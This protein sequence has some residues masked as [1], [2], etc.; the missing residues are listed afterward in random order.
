M[1]V[2]IGTKIGMT[3]IIGE[4]GIVT[5]VTI[6]QAGPATVTQI[7]TVES[8]GYNAVQLGYG[9]GKNLS[10]SVSGHVKKAGENLS[11]KVLKEFRTEGEPEVKIGDI[12]TVESFNLGDKVTVIGTSKG[13]GYAGTVKRWN[14][15][16][17]RNTHGFKGNIRRVGSI[18]SMYPQKVFKGKKMPG[19]MGHDQVTVKNLE[20]AYIDKENNLIGLKGAVPG[21]KKGIVTVEGKE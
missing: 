7:K 9:Q 16:E 18:G 19:R 5:P 8:D 14:F 12:L 6:V 4:D 13:K 20:V 2:I 1:Q 21:P 17:S 15:N 11:P 10:K 3:Q